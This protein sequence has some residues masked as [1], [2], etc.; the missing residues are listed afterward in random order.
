MTTQLTLRY[1]NWN[2]LCSPFDHS[3][4]SHTLAAT[5]YSNVVFQF[6]PFSFSDRSVSLTAWLHKM[7]QCDPRLKCFFSQ[8]SR[9]LASSRS[10]LL[11]SKKPR[12]T[13][14]LTFSTPNLDHSQRSALSTWHKNLTHFSQTR[15]RVLL[16]ENVFVLRFLFSHL[17]TMM[18]ST[19]LDQSPLFIWQL[20]GSWHSF[21]CN[22]VIMITA[23]NSC[24]HISR[25]SWH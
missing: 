23:P 6:T 7:Q 1:A 22:V 19:R 17:G 20:V 3:I 10:D 11:T 2:A 12:S 9:Y 16:Q 15:S 21:L 25:L 8:S 4:F 5:K 24:T 13:W 18:W 14:Q